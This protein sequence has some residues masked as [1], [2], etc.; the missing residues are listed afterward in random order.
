MEEEETELRAGEWQK[1]GRG[2]MNGNKHRRSARGGTNVIKARKLAKDQTEIKTF[3]FSS[4][5]R[6]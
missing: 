2:G 6:C 1:T 3:I 5:S 4:S